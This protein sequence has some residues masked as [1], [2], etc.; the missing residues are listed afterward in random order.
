MPSGVITTCRCAGEPAQT[1]LDFPRDTDALS[2]IWRLLVADRAG[3]ASRIGHRGADVRRR[4]NQ[5]GRFDR[6]EPL[7]YR[8]IVSL[9]GRFQRQDNALR[10]FWSEN[11]ALEPHALRARDG[12]A[13]G[14]KGGPNPP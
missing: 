11:G 6:M 12:E 1:A 8:P 13:C 9:C 2:E 4:W 5:E 14:A 3:P 7:A 10:C